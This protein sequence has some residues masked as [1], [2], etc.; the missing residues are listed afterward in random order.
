MT[1]RTYP[2]VS[3]TV[4]S[5]VSLA[6]LVR[7]IQELPVLISGWAVPMGISWVGFLV[8]AL[9]AVWAFSQ[10]RNPTT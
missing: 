3:G 9:L 5:I 8:T 1:D 7:S 2:A 6:H 10:L 4:F